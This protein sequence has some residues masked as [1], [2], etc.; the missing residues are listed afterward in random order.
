MNI[1][2]ILLILKTVVTELPG[3]ISTGKQLFDLGKKFFVTVNGREPTEA[4]E[5]DLQTQIAADVV[6]ALEPLPPA[7]P[8]DPD[9]EPPAAA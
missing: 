3:A 2:A 5:T 9:Y 8:G 4:E 1:A 7:Q 6:L